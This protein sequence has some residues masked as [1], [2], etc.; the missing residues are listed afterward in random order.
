M[1]GD[2]AKAEA[3]AEAV[4]EAEEE[5]AERGKRSRHTLRG[6][7]ADQPRGNATVVERKDTSLG[8]AL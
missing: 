5:A 7:Q 2:Q 1:W 3:E 8:S 4:E 6:S